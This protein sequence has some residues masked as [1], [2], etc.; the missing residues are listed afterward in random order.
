[1]FFYFIYLERAAVEAIA[2]AVIEC[3]IDISKARDQRYNGA[4]CMFSD[5]VGVQARIKLCMYTAAAMS[6]M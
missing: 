2:H 1:M 5:K 4:Q 3:L 6:S